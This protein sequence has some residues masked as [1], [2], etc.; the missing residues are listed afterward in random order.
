MSE[1]SYSGTG[2]NT[3]KEEAA[4]AGLLRWVGQTVAFGRCKPVLDFGYFASVLESGERDRPGPLDRWR[5][6]QAARRTD[7]GQVRHNRHRLRG[8][9]CQ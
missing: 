7:A 1:A 8:H 6:K 3:I 9:E 4:L 5:G 2:V